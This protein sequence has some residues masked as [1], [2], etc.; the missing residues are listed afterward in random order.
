MLRLKSTVAST[1]ELNY[2]FWGQTWVQQSSPVIQSSGP[3]QWMD[4]P[5]IR[6]TLCITP[7][8]I[9]MYMYLHVKF[10]FIKFRCD[11]YTS[12]WVL[13][14]G[15]RLELTYPQE[16]YTGKFHVCIHIHVYKYVHVQLR[17]L[18]FSPSLFTPSL[19]LSSPTLTPLPLYSPS[20]PSL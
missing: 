10:I 8:I 2:Q 19:S 11:H 4:T 14:T 6:C 15:W 12:E 17:V 1:R 16:L 3:V 18:L 13:C 20:P 9:Y 5:C 7:H